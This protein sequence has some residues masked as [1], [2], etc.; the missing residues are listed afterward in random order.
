MKNRYSKLTWY[1]KNFSGWSED[2]CETCGRTITNAQLKYSQEHYGKKLCKGCQRLEE[3]A[4]P[5]TYESSKEYLE[6]TGEL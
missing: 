3:Y 2:V 5:N 4:E 1:P 6:I